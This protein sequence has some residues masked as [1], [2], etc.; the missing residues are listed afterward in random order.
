MSMFKERQRAVT[1][2][3]AHLDGTTASCALLADLSKAKGRVNPHWIL[4][5]LRS[6]GA[7]GWVIRHS[8]LAICFF[9]NGD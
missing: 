6:K 5:L 7:P 2:I 9:L 1:A 4:A 3:Q 8:V